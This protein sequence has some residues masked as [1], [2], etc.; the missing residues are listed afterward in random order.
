MKRFTV[1]RRE[2]YVIWN[3]CNLYDYIL[4]VNSFFFDSK[5]LIKIYYIYLYVFTDEYLTVC[6]KRQPNCLTAFNNFTI[7]LQAIYLPLN[8]NIYNHEFS[9]QISL[10]RVVWGAKTAAFNIRTR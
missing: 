4:F 3:K 5:I 7:F 9:I 6:A 8:I 10:F 1:D 2:L